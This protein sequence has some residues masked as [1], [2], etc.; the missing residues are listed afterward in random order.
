MARVAVLVLTISLL[1]GCWSR[2]ELN[3]LAIVAGIGIDLADEPGKVLLTAQIIKP[4]EVRTPQT[5]GGGEKR[6]P[7]WVVRSTGDTVF[8]AVRNFTTQSPR[9]LYFPHSEIIVIG[10]E[11][12]ERG[13]RPLLDFFIRDPEPRLSEWVLVADGRASDILEAKLELES[14]PARGLVS[15]VETR[16]A[17]SEVTAVT[18]D[19]FLSRL[20]SRTAAPVATHIELIGNEKE[21]TV[22]IVGTAVFK[23][24]KLVGQLDKPET[25]GL[26]WVIGEVRSGI[27]VVESPEDGGKVSLEIISAKSKIT[28]ELRDGKVYIKVEVHEEGNLGS[29]MS[30]KD[31]ATPSML[32]DLEKRQESAIHGE[33]RAAL[34]KARDLNVDIFGF[35]DAVHRKYP[36]EWREIEPRWEA[37]FPTIDVEVSVKARIRQVG[38]ITKPASP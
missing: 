26:L 9:K 14:I 15:L 20:A 8:D 33:I 2:H 22:R 37:V 18:L 28:P 7:V 6:Q 27:I 19:E 5:G 24:D 34:A 10:K 17:T 35:G 31:L 23:G 1:T 32:A 11:A 12:A 30:A 36:R 21:K 38:M 3:T 4:S 29:Q 16:V 25:R 13:V